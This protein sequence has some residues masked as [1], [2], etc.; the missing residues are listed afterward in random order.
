M[1][2]PDK[3][4]MDFEAVKRSVKQRNEDNN[5]QTL[6]RE[7]ISVIWFVVISKPFENLR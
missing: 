4:E 2:E 3:K 5:L 7:K 1:C 6:Q